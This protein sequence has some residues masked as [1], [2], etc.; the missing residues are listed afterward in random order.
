MKKVVCLRRHALLRLYE[1]VV[2]CFAFS[3]LKGSKSHENG[4][5][6]RRRRDRKHCLPRIEFSCGLFLCLE[7]CCGG[8]ST[9][10]RDGK[11]QHRL[12]IIGPGRLTAFL[13]LS[14]FLWAACHIVLPFEKFVP[15]VH[16]WIPLPS[17]QLRCVLTQPF[18]TSLPS[19]VFH[20]RC[21]IKL[22]IPLCAL[23]HLQESVEASQR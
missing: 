7:I 22:C 15:H 8:H 18:L 1:K 12:D 21:L 23:I 5:N 3:T 20:L 6:P 14:L 16:P 4:R 13:P 9:C 2:F 10:H 11:P 17:L 19:A